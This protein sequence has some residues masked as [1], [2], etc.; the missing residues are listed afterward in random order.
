MKILLAAD[1]S[2]FTKE[3][4]QEC[5]EIISQPRDTI[6]KIISV[7][8]SLIPVSTEPLDFP[9]EYVHE[10]EQKARKSV[11]EAEKN[12]KKRFKD[13]GLKI[14]TQTFFGSPKKMIVAEAEKWK[15]DLIILGT[16]GYGFW[17]RMYMG[18]ISDSVVHHAPCPVL[19]AR[20][21][22]NSKGL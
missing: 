5:C 11:S 9:V 22:E 3:A 6:V 14:E 21:R 13:S 18:S 2:E 12:I 10:L 19:I 17:E 4:V 16:H 7:A 8:N 20:K 15:P 1:N